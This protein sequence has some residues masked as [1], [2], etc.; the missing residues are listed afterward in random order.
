MYSDILLLLTTAILSI[1]IGAQLTEAILFVPYWK[2]L[3]PDQ[4]HIFH[5]IHGKSIHKFYAILTVLAVL[6]SLLTTVCFFIIQSDQIIALTIFGLS[7][8]VYFSTY[9]I[10]FKRA[11]QQFLDKSLNDREIY[12]ALL[13][14]SKWHWFRIIFELIALLMALWLLL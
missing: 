13:R 14:W 12:S 2:S 7:T 9:L 11:N 8:L 4:F 5:K 6:L 1:F 10:F 3:T